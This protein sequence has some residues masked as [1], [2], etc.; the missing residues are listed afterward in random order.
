MSQASA[1]R[2]AIVHSLGDPTQ[3]GLEA[4]Y[5]YFPDGVL[6][7]EDGHISDLGPAE[8][9]LARW[10]A[11]LEV[12]QY[13]HKL[14]TAGFIDT[15]IHYPQTEMIASYGEQ[16][17]D[18]LNNYTFPEEAKFADPEHAQRVASFFLDE[19]LAN[20]T[21]TALVFGSVHTASIDA[22]FR[23]S[24]RRNTRMI[25]GKVMMDRH[26][27]DNL[28]DTADTSYED[29]K[30]LI[31]RWHH[32]GRQ[33]YAVT[34]R[35][36]PTSTPEQ[37]AMAGRLLAEYPDVYLQTHL[38]ENKQ[39]IEWVKSLFPQRS[40]Y[41]DVYDHFGLLGKRSV[42]AHAIHLEQSEWQRLG[43]T[44]SVLSSC[45][46]SNL[47]L[48]SGLFDLSEAER[49]QVRV[50]LGTDHRL[51]RILLDLGAQALDVHIE[52][53]GV[54]HVVRAPHAVDELPPREHPAR[55]AQQVLEKLKLFEWQRHQRTA[56]RDRVPFDVH[57][58]RAG[59]QD[60]DLIGLVR[61][62]F[63]PTP[64]N[65][66]DAG[67]EFAGRVG[68]GHVVVG[69]EFQTHDLVDLTVARG[70]HDHRNTG[71]QA[72]ATAHIGA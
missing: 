61:L 53:L 2:A 16:L 64:Q 60:A 5:Q 36:A 41:L 42:F 19:L 3:L 47:F 58:D 17:L 27:P 69:A 38:S 9:V 32:Q 14:I 71:G 54:A 28:L 56:D 6:V 65:R 35:F 48:G 23:E 25:A 1:Y 20:G 34:P 30:A 67:D 31:E 45:P 29:S 33:L 10:P 55:V 57:A 11:N 4:S 46:T 50:G 62:H 66:A 7:V 22:F 24:E 13:Q 44:D 59:L 70:H 21:T 43:S 39:E 68:L 63:G 52:R 72:Q 37:L 49:Q 8:E 12:V 15:H 40:G 51:A 26:A 18:W